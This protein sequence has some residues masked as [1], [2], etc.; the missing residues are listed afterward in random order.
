M[1]KPA[2]AEKAL[3]NPEETIQF[4]GLSRRKFYALLNKSGRLPFIIMYNKRKLIVRSV[5]E[6][7]PKIME[8]LKS[9]RPSVPQK[10]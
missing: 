3:L 6:A 2:L 10:T 1:R 8:E 9:V 7:N 4:Y 5:F